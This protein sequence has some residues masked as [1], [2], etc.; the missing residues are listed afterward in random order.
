[1]RLRYET[2]VATLVQF[3]VAVSLS[4]LNGIIS[5]IGGCTACANADCVSNTLVSLILIILIV[6]ALG[7]LLV[8]G[9]AAQERRSSRLAKTLIAFEVL[10]ALIYLFDAQHTPN[11]IDRITNLITFVVAVWVILL[12]WRL[13]TAKGGRI[14]RSRQR[15][16]PIPR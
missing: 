9:Y 14:V 6:I 11:I 3:I 2:G 13:A 5:I 4:S 7:F 10:A 16:N 12:A 15:R 1:M 8:L